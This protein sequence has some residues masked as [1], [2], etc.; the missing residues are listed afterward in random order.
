[1]KYFVHRI[2]GLPV[3][4]ADTFP[5]AAQD[6]QRLLRHKISNHISF[7]STKHLPISQFGGPCISSFDTTSGSQAGCAAGVHR[8]VAPAM[9]CALHLV[10]V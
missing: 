1:M 6:V 8:A 2:H 3:V 7:N 5:L 10:Q 4:R 9:R